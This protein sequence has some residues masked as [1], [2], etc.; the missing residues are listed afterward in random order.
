MALGQD[1]YQEILD[2]PTI[3]FS[4]RWALISELD[5]TNQ[6]L[7]Y[8]TFMKSWNSWFFQ[9]F[10]ELKKFSLLE[11][12]SGSGGLSSLIRQWALENSIE[13]EL[14]LYDAQ[15]DV[16]EESLK[17]FSNPKPEI[18]LATPTHL[19]VFADQKFDFVISLHV[20]H[21]IQP[22]EQ[23]ISAIEEM[24][25][26]SKKAVFVVDIEP[27]PFAVLLTRVLTRLMGVSDDLRADGVKS[28]Q[29]SYRSGDLV[30]VLSTKPSFKSFKF[31][32]RRFLSPYFLLK[33]VRQNKK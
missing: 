20:I 21:H 30:G 29:R 27:R 5:G 8:K 32:V 10:Q 18:H 6:K 3:P 7:V 13:V 22:F 16:L 2:D 14:N 19:K 33:S 25:R 15:M 24:H 12:G 17:R 23:A 11:V 28:V 31:E 26:I 9:N 1:P 4:R